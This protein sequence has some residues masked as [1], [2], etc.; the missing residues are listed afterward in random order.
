MGAK[1]PELQ[2][3]AGNKSGKD[4]LGVA[5]AAGL[6]NVSVDRADDTGVNNDTGTY[7]VYRIALGQ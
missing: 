3:N 1:Q 7:T 5:Q 4:E 6:A 2:D